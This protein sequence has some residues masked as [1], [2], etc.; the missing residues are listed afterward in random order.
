L[1]HHIVCDQRRVLAAAE[2]GLRGFVPVVGMRDVVKG[3]GEIIS[4]EL[5]DVGLKRPSV[6]T[7]FNVTTRV[8][9][10]SVGSWHKKSSAAQTDPRNQVKVLQSSIVGLIRVMS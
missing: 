9:R 10:L 2:A 6:I 4:H 1:A 3:H 7:Q 8:D 5:L